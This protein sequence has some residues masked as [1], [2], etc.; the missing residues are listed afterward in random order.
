MGSKCLGKRW[1][2]G[3]LW[4]IEMHGT[5]RQVLGRRVSRFCPGA[6]H[7]RKMGREG[8]EVGWQ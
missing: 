6:K 3:L 2:K 4:M 7:G 5:A 8:K 1:D